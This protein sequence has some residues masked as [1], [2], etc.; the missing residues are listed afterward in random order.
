MNFNQNLTRRPLRCVK[1]T[2]LVEYKEF[3]ARKAASGLARLTK[4]LILSITN[5]LNQVKRNQRNIW[6]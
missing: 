4:K 2:G 3:V 5:K 1:T 6:V